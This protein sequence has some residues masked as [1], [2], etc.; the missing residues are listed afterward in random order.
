VE[1]ADCPYVLEPKPVDEGGYALIFRGVHKKNYTVAAIKTSL[2]RRTR[3]DEERTRA[4][5][6]REIQALRRLRHQHIMPILEAAPD[7]SWYAMPLANGSLWRLHA[8]GSSLFTVVRHVALG[9][10][11]AHSV[12]E[13]HRDAGP[14]NILQISSNGRSRWVVSDW[15]LAKRI[16]PRDQSPLTEAGAPVGTPGFRAPECL[17]GINIDRRADVYTMGRIVGWAISGL[18]PRGVDPVPVS[19]PAWKTFVERATAFAPQDRF[20]SMHEVLVRLSEI[21]SG[22]GVGDGEDACPRCAAPSQRGTRCER[23]GGYLVDYM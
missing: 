4:R 2:A 17:G 15:G 7:H 5:L 13:V 22:I 12:G 21:E 16:Q 6:K 19:D 20:Q 3:K 10:G 8:S 18:V 9:L 11:Y 23:C 14:R 1:L